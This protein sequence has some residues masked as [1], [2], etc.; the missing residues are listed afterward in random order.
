MTEV[1]IC[2][3]RENTFTGAETSANSETSAVGHASSKIS[4]QLNLYTNIKLA[5]ISAHMVQKSL[6]TNIEQYFAAKCCNFVVFFSAVAIFL[7][8]LVH[9]KMCFLPEQ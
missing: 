6:S 1:L 4:P 8:G 7:F 5:I 3:C 9:T 2:S